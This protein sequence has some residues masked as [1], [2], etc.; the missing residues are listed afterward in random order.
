MN[1]KLILLVEDNPDDEVLTLNALAKGNILHTTV[2][3]RDGQEALDYLFREGDYSTRLAGNPQVI[4]L[5]LKLP[6][7]NGLDVLKRIRENRETKLIP[8]VILTSSQ[9]DKD[10]AESYAG[11][12][13][14]YIVKP[15]DIQKFNESINNFINYWL[16]LNRGLE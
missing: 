5:D 13:N 14:G 6:K 4:L 16:V 9:E 2:V 7:I 1:E 15:V 3:V 12:A 8:I 10:I 11:G